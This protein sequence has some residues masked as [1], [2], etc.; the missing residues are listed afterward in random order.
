MCLGRFDES[1]LAAV[2]M[3]PPADQGQVPAEG[4]SEE[5]SEGDAGDDSGGDTEQTG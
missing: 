2:A 4:E 3:A 5:G 1:Q